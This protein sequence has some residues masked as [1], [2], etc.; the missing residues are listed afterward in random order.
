MEEKIRKIIESI[1][2]SVL[3]EEFE[4]NGKNIKFI[5]DKEN[6]SYSIISD[7]KNQTDITL[8]ELLALLNIPSLQEAIEHQ[9]SELEKENNEV[10]EKRESYFS[11]IDSMEI[12]D[13]EKNNLK[14]LVMQITIP[15]KKVGLRNRVPVI[16]PELEQRRED[17]QEHQVEYD[18][19]RNNLLKRIDIA[20]KQLDSANESEKQVARED[21]D[22]LYKQLSS[23]PS[24]PDVIG[25]DIRI[26]EY[27]GIQLVTAIDANITIHDYKDMTIKEVAEFVRGKKLGLD[28]KL[29][30]RFNQNEK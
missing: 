2:T 6:N 30:G 11:E 5:H 1:N 23:I 8:N 14:A 20:S 4:V 3:G 12:P 7:G 17:F 25:Q 10:K 19:R 21:L 15:G 18:T 22:N 24:M 29:I 9:Y 28:E 13:E 27:G 16:D 26:G